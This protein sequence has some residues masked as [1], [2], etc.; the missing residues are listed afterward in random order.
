MKFD[1]DEA[2]NK[3]NI[4]ERGV[5]FADAVE[6]FEGLML[7]ALDMQK[8]YGEER[9]IGLRHI[10]SR[11]AYGRGLHGTRG[12]LDSDYFTQKGEQT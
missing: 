12:G 6:M 11:S 2:K 4:R 5:D 7:V 8:G 3:K 1:W 9:Y 10:H